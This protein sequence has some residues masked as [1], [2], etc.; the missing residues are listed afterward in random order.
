M[1]HF[2]L[3]ERLTQSYDWLRLE[4]MDSALVSCL[5]RKISNF[6]VIDNIGYESAAEI[7][8]SCGSVGEDNRLSIGNIV[9]AWGDFWELS[10]EDGRSLL[11][12][13]RDRRGLV[14]RTDRVRQ[15]VRQ[16]CEAGEF[17][18]YYNVFSIVEMPELGSKWIKS[19]IGQ[20][21]DSIEI[22]RLSWPDASYDLS[23][24][25]PDIFPDESFSVD[26]GATEWGGIQIS[27]SGGHTMCIGPGL[28]EIPGVTYAAEFVIPCERLEPSMIAERRLIGV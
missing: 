12:T 23:E 16:L 6:S 7:L 4:N 8:R 27:C 14:G 19:L 10:F 21:I 13:H 22:L 20:R 5:G 11:L 15:H 24:T 9:D 26:P 17:P 25:A 18:D 2:H 3:V 28:V 1:A